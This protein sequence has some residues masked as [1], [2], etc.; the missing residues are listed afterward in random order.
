MKK[1]TK[2]N[3]FF[4]LPNIKVHKALGL[5]ALLAFSMTACEK[6]PVTTGNPPTTQTGYVPDFTKDKFIPFMRGALTT[7][8]DPKYATEYGKIVKE[9]GYGH[10]VA[11]IVCDNDFLYF[12]ADQMHNLQ[13]IFATLM[14]S[15]GVNNIRGAGNLVGNFHAVDSAW[16]VDKM[17]FKVNAR[18]AN[19]N[20]EPAYPFSTLAQIGWQE[21]P[22]VGFLPI[23]STDTKNAPPK[24]N[25]AKQHIARNMGARHR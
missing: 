3:K 15:S 22:G 2:P 19:G 12:N 5:A 13:Q 20:Y 7:I 14:A 25:P 23:D 8:K 21:V 17:G 10:V 24:N 16:F 4:A 9:R 18:D 6:E 11:I 1:T